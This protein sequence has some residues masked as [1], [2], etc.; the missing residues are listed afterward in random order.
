MYQG[1]EYKFIGKPDRDLFC[2]ICK[3]I[4][5]EPHQT[6][7]CSSL[8]CKSCVP[9]SECM[10]CRNLKS[11]SYPDKRS[12]RRIQQMEVL[13][14]NAPHGL[15]CQWRGELSDVAEHRLEC[16]REHIS[17]PFSKIGCKEE[18]NRC[19]VE[20]HKEKH[21]QVHLD[22]SL[23]MVLS[24]TTAVEG[25]QEQLAQQKSALG[26]LTEEMKRFKMS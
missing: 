1:I 2:Q 15:E 18:M 4:A 8:L 17:C 6:S 20:T 3:E 14:P 16:Q 19:D 23:E 13:C 10:I 9:D 22:L 11:S 24:L 21:K 12:Q 26:S 5:N 25:L 7:C